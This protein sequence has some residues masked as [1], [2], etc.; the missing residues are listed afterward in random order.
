MKIKLDIGETKTLRAKPQRRVLY[1]IR[2]K[3]TSAITEL[4][5]QDIIEK[6]PE[7]E[8][9]RWV[10]PIVAIPKKDGQ[11]RIQYVSMYGSRMKL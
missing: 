11:V 2:E 5:S 7:N 1:H 10:S 6:V 9:T 8:A 4:E 3:V